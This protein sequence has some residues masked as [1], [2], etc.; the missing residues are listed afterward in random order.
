MSKKP[1]SWMCLHQPTPDMLSVGC[2]PLNLDGEIISEAMQCPYCYAFAFLP[3]FSALVSALYKARWG[4]STEFAGERIETLMEDVD[5]RLG[6]VAKV[7]AN[8]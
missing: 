2:E 7:A 1:D 6:A 5:E 3:G 4:D 8:A